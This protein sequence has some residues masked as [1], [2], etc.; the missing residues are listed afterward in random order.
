MLYFKSSLKLQLVGNYKNQERAVVTCWDSW[1]T[2]ISLQKNLGQLHLNQR[3]EPAL[4]N[5][6][7]WF[8][9]KPYA[10]VQKSF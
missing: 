10:K 4:V 5:I 6:F 2:E 1:K 9:I 8:Y 3:G 7:D